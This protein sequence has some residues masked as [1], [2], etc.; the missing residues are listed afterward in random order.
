MNQA[1]HVARKLRLPGHVA[2]AYAR[3]TPQNGCGRPAASRLETRTC[4]VPTGRNVA[5]PVSFFFFCTCSR[6]STRC[7]KCVVFLLAL[8][9]FLAL[10]VRALAYAVSPRASRFSCPRRQARDGCTTAVGEVEGPLAAA[11]I[12]DCAAGARAKAPNYHARRGE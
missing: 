9:T 2:R 7:W 12:N 3:S 6:F 10:E 1:A 11:L 8:P 5:A 4:A